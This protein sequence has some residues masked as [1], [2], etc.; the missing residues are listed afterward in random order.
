[1]DGCSA[2]KVE[3]SHNESPAIRI[4]RPACNRVVY[5]RRPDKDEDQERSQTGA[6]CDGPDGEDRTKANLNKAMILKIDQIHT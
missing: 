5:Y 4:P 3:P 6:L 2:S 1:V